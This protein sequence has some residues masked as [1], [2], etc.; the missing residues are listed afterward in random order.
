M[1]VCPR[2]PPRPLNRF[3]SY[4]QEIYVLYPGVTLSI[5]RDLH[6]KVKVIKTKKSRKNSGFFR[7]WGRRPHKIIM[8]PKASTKNLFRDLHVKVKVIKTKKSRK[9]SGF[10]RKWGRRPHKIHMR[11]KAS[12]KKSFLWPSCQGHGPHSKVKV[13]KTKKSRKISVFFQKWGRRRH[14]IHMRP[15]ASTKKIFFVTFMSRSRS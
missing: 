3:S 12:T 2:T 15:E 5:F 14:K 1:Y 6:L 8:R 13:I 9:N 10:F 7:K 11:P 4:F